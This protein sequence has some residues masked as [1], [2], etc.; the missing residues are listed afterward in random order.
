MK[1]LPDGCID[2]TVTSPPYDNLRNYNGYCFDFEAT[3]RELFRVTADGGVVVWIVADATIHGSET[4]SSFRQALY[5]KETGF[6]LLDTMIWCKDGGGACG[7]NNA[8]T[9][10]TEYM[11]VFTKEK[12]KTVNLI[13]DHVNQRCG[14]V[15]RGHGRRMKNGEEKDKNR[16]RTVGAYGKRNNWWLMS[17][18][19]GYGNHPA[20]FPFELARDH[21][22][23]WSNPGDIVLDPFLGSGTTA[24][25]AIKTGRNYVGFEIS[26]EYCAIA[27]TRIEEAWRITADE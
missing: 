6:R 11:F 16:V 13:R 15:K 8:Y 23:T 7:S 17:R 14:N 4:G 5:F 2:L 3:A 22:L 27:N 1:E 20:V 26:S 21:I 24:V 12:P 25:A 10:N 19:R 18:P 9:Q